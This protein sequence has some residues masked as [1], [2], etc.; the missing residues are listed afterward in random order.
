MWE[1]EER[2]LTRERGLWGPTTSSH[3][4]KWVL[5][6]TEGPCRMRKNMV[7]NPHFYLHYPPHK[8]LSELEQGRQSKYK[9]ACSFHSEEYYRKWRPLGLANRY[10][11]L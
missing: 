9:M 3:L 4:D 2:E 8:R 10:H 5:D 1:K 6:A 7:T 11:Y